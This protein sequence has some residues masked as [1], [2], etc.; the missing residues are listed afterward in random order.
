MSKYIIN[1][2][3]LLGKLGSPLESESLGAAEFDD[4]PD[5]LHASSEPT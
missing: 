1:D 2:G 3:S 4:G 5:F